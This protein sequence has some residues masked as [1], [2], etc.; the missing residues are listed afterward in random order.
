MRVLVAVQ[1]YSVPGMK[2]S[3]FFVQV[4]N[5]YYKKFGL[6]IDVLNFSTKEDYVIDD[7]KVYS[8]NSAL[9]RVK[10]GEY[11]ILISHQPNLRSHLF[12]FLKYS[13]YFKK[14][15]HVFHG[16]EVLNVRKVY[17][18]P[19][20]FDKSNKF[21]KNIFQSTY[22][23]LKLIIWN[24]VYSRDIV[25]TH[26]LFVSNWMYDEFL[27][28]TKVDKN[29]FDR[30]SSITYNCVGEYF[31]TNNYS[32]LLPKEFD[33]ITIRGNLNGSKYCIDLINDLAYN[34][35]NMSFLVVGKGTVWNYIKKAPNI[36]WLDTFLTHDEIIKLLDKSKC[37]LMPTRTDAQGL[38]MCEMA[39]FGIPVITSDI[40]VC[41]EVFDD[42]ENVKFID[43]ND[44]KTDLE[45]ILK[46]LEAGLPYT[47][48]TKYFAENTV[49]KE[50]KLIRDFFK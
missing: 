21:F 45:V 40:K 10:K 46:E 16:H 30:V 8:K 3:H 18:K 35:P 34:N 6:D 2:V 23:N 39:T 27:K 32:L 49:V 14:K 48:N 28:W 12:F 47:K 37:A 15:I 43:N 7:I 41:H 1:T 25:N 24:K 50:V 38:M 5:L 44:L 33:F 22:D 17:S 19:Y 11:D 20:S 26:Y 13:K 29:T 9:V 4:R 31:E 42:F 36:T